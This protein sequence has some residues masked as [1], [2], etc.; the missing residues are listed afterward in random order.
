[1]Q[2]INMRN[3]MN[4]YAETLKSFQA[5]SSLFPLMGITKTLAISITALYL[6]KR[7][8]VVVIT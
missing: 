4:R 3:Q 6:K 7:T 8:R 2:L 1:M 5:H